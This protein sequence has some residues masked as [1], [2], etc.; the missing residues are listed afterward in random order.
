MP[1]EMLRVMAARCEFELEDGVWYLL[2]GPPELL[3]L[4]RRR[5]LRSQLRF[6]SVLTKF[7][8]RR[9]FPMSLEAPGHQISA[10]S[11]F[12]APEAAAHETGLPRALR[13]CLS[14]VPYHLNSLPALTRS[15]AVLRAQVGSIPRARRQHGDPS[16]SCC[17]SLPSARAVAAQLP[18]RLSTF[19]D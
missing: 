17:C 9:E 1:E 7:L 13:M 11:S 4:A 5:P 6:V 2:D 14:G 16:G 8:S 12:S 19:E 10:Y 3:Q 18:L 15:C